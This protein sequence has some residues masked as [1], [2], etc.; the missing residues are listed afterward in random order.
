MAKSADTTNPISRKCSVEGCDGRYL[1]KGLCSKHYQRL[2]KRGDL[3]VSIAPYGAPQDWLLAHKDYQ[4][5][6]CLTWPFGKGGGNGRGVV[7]FGERPM[8][9]SRAMCIIAHGPPPFQKAEAAHS[10]GK[11]H[12]ACVNQK[13]LRWATSLENKFDK[14]VHGTSNRG[15]RH[16]LAKLT[17][18]QVRA[19]RA[20]ARPNA[21][22]AADYP[23]SRRTIADIKRRA[24]WQHVS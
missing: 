18:E 19:I 22:I 23:V 3:D 15:E 12:Q 8:V 16:P 10:C 17:V 9:A 7:K 11:G 1:A 14:V 4:G 13:H 5:D 6:E 24:A 2:T 20:D 21:V